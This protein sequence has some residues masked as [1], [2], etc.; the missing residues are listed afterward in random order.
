M[1]RLIQFAPSPT[2]GP[3][4]PQKMARQG[5]QIIWPALVLLSLL[6]PTS[7]LHAEAA[8]D[9]QQHKSLVDAP[10]TTEN[11]YELYFV[12]TE[13]ARLRAA[14]SPDET[15]IDARV[16]IN[17]GAEESSGRFSLNTALG[18]WADLDTVP[19]KDQA[20]SLREIHDSQNSALW[21]DVY[22]L[23]AQYKGQGLLRSA[24]LGR[25]VVDHGLPRNIDGGEVELQVLSHWLGLYA[26]GGRSVHFFE[27]EAGMF[28]DWVG[29]VGLRSRPLRDLLLEV[30]TELQREDTT[31]EKGLTELGYSAQVWY[32]LDRWLDARA[33]LRGIDDKLSHTGGALRLRWPQMG[34]GAELRLRSQLIELNALSE[35]E[36]P[37]FAILGKAEPFVRTRL[38]AWKSLTTSFGEY[39]LHFGL[40]ARQLI[41]AEATHF[42]RN[43]AYAYSALSAQDIV[44]KGP[45]ARIAVER[46]AVSDDFAASN[47]S[48]H[49]FWTMSGQVGYA[50]GALAAELG[51]R[52]DAYKYTYYHSVDEQQNVQS[53]FASLNYKFNDKYSLRGRY[54]YEHFA[55]D[56][57]SFTL[58]FVQVF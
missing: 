7:A 37:Y 47:L 5:A 12:S 49:G 11:A 51:S 31:E 13:Q 16:F 44:V 35:S 8:S 45:Y 9:S 58:S 10:V 3:Q 34:L 2:A 54:L 46:Q 17:A 29:A 52:F 15:D 22:S 14:L 53:Y 56:V 39:A 27:A 1:K 26:Y 38:D 20:T 23:Q 18:I 57:H 40:E 32:R 36:D 6:W 25:V 43:F 50:K 19:A 55:W 4:A 24:R 42:N 48:G 41:K 28:E 33:Y 30:E 21:L